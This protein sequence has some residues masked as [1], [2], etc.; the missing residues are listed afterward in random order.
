MPD[1]APRPADFR[2]VLCTCPDQTV[3]RALARHLVEAQLAACVNLVPGLTS[4]YRWRGELQEGTEVL[5]LIKTTARRYAALES[6][7]RA[8]HPYELP[9]I[10]GVT[11][12][13]GLPD[14]LDWISTSLAAAP[15]SS[16]DVTS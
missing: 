4:L 1:T 16:T 2:L 3:A 14:Y 10:I 11:L 9:E 12:D 7:I 8:R 13:D 5:L 15:A 6:A